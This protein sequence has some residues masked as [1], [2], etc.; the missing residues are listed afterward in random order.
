[1]LHCAVGCNV[2]NVRNAFEM[3]ITVNGSQRDD[4]RGCGVAC[5]AGCGG[6]FTSGGGD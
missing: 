5:L 4:P 1:M 2:A 6:V 3:S